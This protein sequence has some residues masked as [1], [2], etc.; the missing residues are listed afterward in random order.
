M[1]LRWSRVSPQLALTPAVAITLVAFIGAILWTIYMSFTESKAFASYGI[2][3]SE[4]GGAERG[5]HLGRHAPLAI[6][7]AEPGNGCDD[8]IERFKA[9]LGPLLL[10]H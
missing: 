6:A 8:V 3:F 4:L 2:D 7:A 9:Q 5:C 10:G 1:A